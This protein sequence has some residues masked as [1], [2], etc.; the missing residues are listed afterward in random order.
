MYEYFTESTSSLYPSIW[1]V[2]WR[3]VYCSLMNST[4]CSAIGPWSAPFPAN[5]ASEVTERTAREGGNGAFE[6]QGPRPP[7]AGYRHSGLQMAWQLFSGN[8][9][10]DGTT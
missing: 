7:Q 4:T 1:F 5:A 10:M 8:L 2:N 6:Q 9:A 3:K